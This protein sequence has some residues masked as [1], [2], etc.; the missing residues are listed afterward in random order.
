MKKAILI[1]SFSP[2]DRDP[3]VSRQIEFLKD[4]YKVTAAGFTRPDV[5]DISFIPL[6]DHHASLFKKLVQAIRIKSGRFDRYYWK[7]AN[8]RNAYDKLFGHA[9]NLIIANDL[10]S[11]PLS[12]KLAVDND[13]KVFL[14]AH[15]YEPL[16]FD[17]KWHFNFFFQRLLALYC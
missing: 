14:D 9:S 8:I 7:I 12:L 15:E 5:Q 3:R 2:I 4:D 10:N 1:L 16:H 6:P 17:N 11:L 13:A